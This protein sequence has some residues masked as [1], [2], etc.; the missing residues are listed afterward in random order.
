MGKYVTNIM[1]LVV[2]TLTNGSESKAIVETDD[3]FSYFQMCTMCVLL[4]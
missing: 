1:D 3:V 4:K 2:Q